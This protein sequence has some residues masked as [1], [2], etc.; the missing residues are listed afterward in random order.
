MPE[1]L[2]T[3]AVEAAVETA[4]PGAVET[5]APADQAG[6]PSEPTSDTPKETAPEK[7]DWKAKAKE[8]AD[9]SAF[10]KAEAN[11]LKQRELA[12]ER[13][14]SSV[15][16]IDKALETQ[17][18]DGAL[19]TLKEVRTVLDVADE[20]DEDTPAF[21]RPEWREK[22]TAARP[23]IQRL[24]TGDN[25]ELY[26]AVFARHGKAEMDKRYMADPEEFGNW[27]ISEYIDH[28]AEQKAKKAAPVVAEALATEKVAAAMQGMPVPLNGAGSQAL[29]D[30]QKLALYADG[31]LN[32]SRKDYLE[33]AA[34]RR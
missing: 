23:L 19:D 30:E 14:Q 31:K 21:A 25:T 6:A 24:T 7:V 27:L 3:T 2:G 18:F 26:A 15:K 34:R 17:D 22:E 8:D 10:I 11:R 28:K 13:R 12:R 5:P 9:L 29:S 1:E 16:R 4:A 33:I 32:L 20:P